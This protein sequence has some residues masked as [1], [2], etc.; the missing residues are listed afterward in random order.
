VTHKS[1]PQIWNMMLSLPNL[2]TIEVIGE[3]SANR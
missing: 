1:P 2:H 3:Y